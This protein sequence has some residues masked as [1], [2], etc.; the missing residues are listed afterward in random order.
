MEK[1]GLPIDVQASEFAAKI[2]NIASIFAG[3]ELRAFRADLVK[4][5]SGWHVEI[6]NDQVGFTMDVDQ[7]ETFLV[8]ADWTC[9]SDRS[10][11]WLK[12]TNSTYGIYLVDRPGRPLFRYDYAADYDS[13]LPK[14]HVHFHADHPDINPSQP[15]KDAQASLEHLGEGS[16]RAR[17]RAK[18]RKRVNL[19]DLHFPV[20]GTRFRPALEDILLMMLEEY[21]V[22]PRNMESNEAVRILRKT[23]V[24]WRKSQVSA[25]IRDMPTLAIDFF[26]SQGYKLVPSSE[27]ST[28]FIL[29]S[30]AF[31][32]KPEKLID[33]RE[34]SSQSIPSDY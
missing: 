31:V 17:R 14:A 27:V 26:E 8:T 20:G 16:K 11:S 29:P 32:D 6:H 24:D 33:V 13:R 2:N 28:N 15:M 4:G 3:E 12:V 34:W 21:G 23:L 22:E 7:Q 30:N 18:H 5:D 19:S 9:T 1:N 25:V 10:G